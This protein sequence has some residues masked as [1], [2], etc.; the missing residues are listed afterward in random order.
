M[1]N[2]ADPRD[3]ALDPQSES[4]MD[5][6]AVLPQI[7]IPRIRLLRQSLGANAR[8]QLLVVVLA[9]AAADD[10]SVPLR[11]KTVVVQHCPRIGGIL[12]HVKSLHRLRVVVDEHPAIVLLRPHRLVLATPGAAP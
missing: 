1:R 8:P 11:R 9:L 12:L 2:A 3:R 5:E 7:E 10:F 6:R 4:G